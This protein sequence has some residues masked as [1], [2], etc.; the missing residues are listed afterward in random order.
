MDGELFESR[1]HGCNR[2]PFDDTNLYSR[3][4]KS[5][6]TI[7]AVRPHICEFGDVPFGLNRICEALDASALLIRGQF[8]WNR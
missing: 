4:P 7:A 5:P 1:C 2:P 3:R 8:T 6:I